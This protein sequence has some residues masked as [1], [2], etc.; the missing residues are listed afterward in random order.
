MTL[1]NYRSRQVHKTLNGVNPSSRFRDMHSA[2]FS[3]DPICGKSDKFLAHGQA[4]MRQMGKWPWLTMHNYRHRQFHRTSNGK[5]P[6]SGYRD[7]GS[8][9]LAAARPPEPWQQYPSSPKGWGIKSSQIFCL[10]PKNIIGNTEH[11]PNKGVWFA[12]HDKGV[13]LSSRFQY[14]DFTR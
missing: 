7:M 2:I 14:K 9:S 6:S 12:L 5:N 1:H 11:V 10:M 3:L 4:H 8:A 13:P